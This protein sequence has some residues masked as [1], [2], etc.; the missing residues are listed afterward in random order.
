MQF[1]NNLSRRQ[2][3][4]QVARFGGACAGGSALSSRLLPLLASP[5]AEVHPLSAKPAHYAP[6]AN[7]VIM[8]FLT[9]GASHVD[10]FDPKPELQAKDGMIFQKTSL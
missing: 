4:K 2:M 6:K 8:F 9:G 1:R 7:R 10:S 3:L 5:T